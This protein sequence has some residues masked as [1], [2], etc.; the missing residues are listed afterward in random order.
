MYASSTINEIEAPKI[1]RDASR[2]YRDKFRLMNQ[3]NHINHKNQ[4]SDNKMF[5]YLG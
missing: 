4:S 3:K 2:L 1:S 5:Q